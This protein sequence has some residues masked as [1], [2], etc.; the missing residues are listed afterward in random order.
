MK[1]WAFFLVLGMTRVS[2]ASS[3]TGEI[4]FPQDYPE[5]DSAVL[6]AEPLGESSKA[7]PKIKPTQ[8]F[9]DQINMSFRPYI[10]VVPVGSTLI[11]K[12]S[13]PATHGL[14]AQEGP[15]KNLRVVMTAK[16][17]EYRFQVKETGVS[18]L[19][20]HIHAQ[21]K[22]WVLSVPTNN[23][24]ISTSEGKFTL[25]ELPAYP[26]TLKIWHPVLPGQEIKIENEKDL[27]K[28][29]KI[30]LKTWN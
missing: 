3:L 13:D 27:V 29:K 8:A 22:A 6:W 7:P 11:F 15:L 12:N 26:F 28:G 16:Q 24:A 9:I 19:L 1:S 20:C 4:N 17:K 25:A 23:F 18:E 14:K 2:A 30:E 21:M 10:T 5:K